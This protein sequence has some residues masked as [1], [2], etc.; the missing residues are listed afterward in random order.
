MAQWE[1]SHVRKRTKAALQVP[2]TRGAS[3]G[4][5]RGKVLALV[6]E[7]ARAS[8]EASRRGAFPTQKVLPQ[9][10]LARSEGLRTYKAV[11]AYL[12]RRG[13]RTARAVPTSTGAAAH[14]VSSIGRC[15]GRPQLLH[16]S[17]F[18]YRSRV[19]DGGDTR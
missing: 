5:D 11:A 15:S 14:H 2:K 18:Q 12:S 8:A 9:I 13:I 3:V 19:M 7:T 1:R 16:R 4:G 17:A 10:Q 6:E